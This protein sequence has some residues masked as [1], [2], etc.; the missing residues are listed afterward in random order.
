MRMHRILIVDDEPI[1]LS[2]IKSL[3]NW[4]TLGVEIAGTARNGQEALSFIEAHHPDIVI[5]DIKMPIMDGIS[6]LKES[7]ERFP[8][9]V[10][11][12]LSSLEEFR[13][14]KE[15]ISYRA[16]DYLLKIELD[17]KQLTE[18]VI[19]AKNESDKRS[20]LYQKDNEL[21]YGEGKA[22]RY[23]SNLLKFR[24]VISDRRRALSNA[25][26]TES[27]A[28]IGICLPKQGDVGSEGFD[29]DM[30][31]RYEWAR[32]IA[33]KVISPFFPS[34]HE[35]EPIASRCVELNYFLTG[36]PPLSWNRNIALISE[37]IQNAARMVLNLDVDFI[38]SGKYQGEENLEKARDDFEFQMTKHYLGKDEVI[39]D[40]LRLDNAL[41]KVERA[42]SSKDR[43]AFDITTRIIRDRFENTDH[44]KHHAAFFFEALSYAVKSGFKGTDL[45][46]EGLKIAEGMEH[47]LV[48]IEKISDSIEMLDNFERDVSTLLSSSGSHNESIA[49][50]KL[51]ILS[52]LEKQM[53]LSE[54]AD[55]S[56]ISPGYLSALFKKTTGIS[57]V[58]YVNQAKIEKAKEMIAN[59]MRR[60]DE[61][62][63]ALGFEN[64]YYFSKVFKKFTGLPP[65]EYARK[66]DQD[67]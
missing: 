35:V 67:K 56:C 36:F 24:D 10:F 49:K 7:N 6:L 43:Q 33:E 53:T 52:H 55:N 66:F 45:E 12:M 23:I 21:E 47:D 59:G 26:F 16:V 60:V 3:L 28:F 18:A 50:A 39:L 48:Y 37:K 2:G 13:L 63:S 1:I 61:M 51:Y 4:E 54:I 15:A 27:F 11:I 44:M 30:E 46:S 34:F 57:V 14:A 31:R 38:H 9:V 19:K 58:D 64:I 8:D 5:A 29:E 42:L 65:T 41:K 17:E 22:E 20:I 62:A 40:D 32:Q 25:G